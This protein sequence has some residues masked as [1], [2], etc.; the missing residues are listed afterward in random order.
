MKYRLLVY[1]LLMM[2][3]LYG[4]HLDLA[5]ADKLEFLKKRLEMSLSLLSA[6]KSEL[7]ASTAEKHAQLQK[8]VDDLTHNVAVQ[9]NSLHAL[10]RQA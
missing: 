4:A 1:I 9:R 2:A 8:K 6:R 7:S 3:P 5:Q 10:E